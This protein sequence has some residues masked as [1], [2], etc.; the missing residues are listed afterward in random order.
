M[1][2]EL[3][4]SKKDAML[5]LLIH[6]AGRDG[7][8]TDRELKSLTNKM[9]FFDFDGEDIKTAMLH[10]SIY[11]EHI[12]MEYDFIEFLLNIITIE[13]SFGLFSLCFDIAYSDTI[14]EDSESI[15]KIIAQK[16]NV[17]ESE[18]SLIYLMTAQKRVLQI[19]IKDD[20]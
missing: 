20:L 16:L 10:Y 14:D 1:Y 7:E 5:A 6:I 13:E 18:Y 3:I 4:H 19:K 9:S 8:Y 11:H 17:N 12:K 15:L 2:Q